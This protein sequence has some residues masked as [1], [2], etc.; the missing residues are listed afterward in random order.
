MI[1]NLSCYAHCNMSWLEFGTSIPKIHNMRYVLQRLFMNGILQNDNDNSISRICQK[2]RFIDTIMANIL[3]WFWV[4]FVI[5]SIKPAR[6]IKMKR[7]KVF[8]FNFF[9]TSFK[10][11][12]HCLFFLKTVYPIFIAT[13][14]LSEDENISV[15][16]ARYV[17]LQ[18]KLGTDFSSS[19]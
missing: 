7:G 8:F 9:H 17:L 16:D 10:E 18:V 6:D 5:L 4:I 3:Y 12:R 13:F 11:C 1:S 15:V 14:E 19:Y 2:E